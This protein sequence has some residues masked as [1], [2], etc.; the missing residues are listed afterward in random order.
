MIQQDETTLEIEQEE[1]EGKQ[2]YFEESTEEQE[3]EYFLSK[4]TCQKSP[5]GSHP[6]IPRRLKWGHSVLPWF[7]AS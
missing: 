3:Q 6:S 2:E 5:S 4:S 1:E 7:F